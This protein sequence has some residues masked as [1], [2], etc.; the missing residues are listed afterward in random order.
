MSKKYR[1]LVVDDEESITY[2]VKTELED[3][4]EFDVDTSFSGSEAI[5]LIRSKIYDVVCLILK[6][7]A[8]AV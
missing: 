8:L 1:V 4:A 6:C 3:L 7:L 5:N 2:L